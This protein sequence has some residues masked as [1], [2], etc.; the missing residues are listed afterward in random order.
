MAKIL[1]EHFQ[2]LAFVIVGSV[3]TNQE[4]F[5]R[6]V[7]NLSDQLKFSSFYWAGYRAD[8]RALLNKFD[9]YV[10]TSV[11]ESGPMTIWEAMSMCKPI[12][13]TDVGDVS[14]YIKDQENGFIVPV[15]DSVKLASRVSQLIK[16]PSLRVKFGEISRQIAQKHLN[17]VKCGER[18]LEA[19]LAVSKTE[20]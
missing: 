9:V 14:L 6:S 2:N 17:I 7:K 1:D 18:H 12:V 4:N 5:F 11:Y 10:C 8:P 15:G 20:L 16:D 19:Y 3:F 13:S